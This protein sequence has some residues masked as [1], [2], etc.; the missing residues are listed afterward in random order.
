MNPKGISLVFSLVLRCSIPA[1]TPTLTV[2]V[3]QQPIR[4]PDE[5]PELLGIMHRMGKV[6]ANCRP[7]LV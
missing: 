2:P 3:P 5:K 1:G 6:Q 7:S 4:L